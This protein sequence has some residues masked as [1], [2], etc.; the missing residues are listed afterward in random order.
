MHQ[1]F[2]IV[3][4]WGLGIGR[5]DRVRPKESLVVRRE[6]EKGIEGKERAEG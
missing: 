2:L 6:R 1:I 5:K 3:E 4:G